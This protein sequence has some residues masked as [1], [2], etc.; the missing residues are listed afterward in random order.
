MTSSISLFMR[1]GGGRFSL[2]ARLV[3][4]T[5]A[6]AACSACASSSHMGAAMGG[7]AVAPSPDPR[8]SLKAGWF[9]AGQATWNMTLEAA[10]KPSSAFFNPSGATGGLTNSDLAFTG[11]HYVV[12]GNYSGFQI[13]DVASPS[14]PKVVTA[15]VCGGVQGDVSVFRNLLFV[16]VESPSGRLDCG[17]QGVKDSVSAERFR[18]VRIFDISDIAHPRKVVDVQ[19]CRGSHT[20]TVVPD[21]RDS[22]NVYVYVDAL[23]PARSSTE[24]AG[25][26]DAGEDH[27]TTERFR[28]DVIQVPLAHPEQSKVVT[29]PRILAD[30]APYVRHEEYAADTAAESGL[31]KMLRAAPSGAQAAELSPLGPIATAC[32]DITVYPAVGLA[33]AACIGYG[34][35]LDIH[36]VANPRRITA[37]SDTNFWGWHSATFNNDG[38]EVL[39]SDEWGGGGAPRCRA[40]DNPKWGGDAVYRIGGDHLTLEG[41][42]KLPVA[43]P[44]TKN[45]VAHNGSLIPIPGRTVMVQSWYQGGVSVF[46]WTDAAHP[47]EIA[48][49][50]R[51]PIDSTKLADGGTWSAYWWNGNI[52]SSEITRGLDVLALNASPL[53]TQNEL[54]AAKTVTFDQYNVQDQQRFVWKPSFVVA[55][56]YLDQLARDDGLPAARR[57]E[58][59]KALAAAEK[60]SG[61]ARSGAL[62]TVASGLESDAGSAKDAARVKMLAAVVRGIGGA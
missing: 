9:D 25:C 30:L 52:Y 32:H 21:P 46:D 26:S 10:A 1:P 55:R 2:L 43:Q 47:K 20:N 37:A 19:T 41:Y 4:G 13:W 14:A 8:L 23:V 48:Y 42:Y 45:C 61:D 27:P 6:A 57:E 28:I 31:L 59:S 3:A 29:R 5:V 16:S 24:L 12:Q 39:F 11:G 36:D 34:L 60:M 56:A 7:S 62:A 15:Y 50:D 35:L 51:G 44:A 33:G 53:I 40:T 38:T 18:G 22:A 58:V 54:D 49:F 17:L